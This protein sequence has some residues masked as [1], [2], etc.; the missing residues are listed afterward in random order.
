[1]PAR[2]AIAALEWAESLHLRTPAGAGR[3]MSRPGATTPLRYRTAQGKRWF[4]VARFSVGK[5]YGAEHEG[6]EESCRGG[7]GMVEAVSLK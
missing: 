7:Y 2:N 6:G 4:G 3:T 1:M 5:E